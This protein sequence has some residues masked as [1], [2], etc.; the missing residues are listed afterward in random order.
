MTRAVVV[1]EVEVTDEFIEWWSTF[2]IEQQQEVTDRIELLSERGPDLGRL[3]VD[4]IHTSRH[5][6]MKV[7]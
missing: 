5:Q 7:N 2:T 6:S 4:L 3:V 1:W